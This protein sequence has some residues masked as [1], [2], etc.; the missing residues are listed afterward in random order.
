MTL[1]MIRGLVFGLACVVLVVCANAVEVSLPEAH[2]DVNAAVLRVVAAGGGRV[3]VPK[4][5]WPTPSVK[6]ASNV[7]LFLADGARIVA[8]TNRSDYM[9]LNLPYCEG[10]LM[11]IVT[12]VGATNVAITGRG[13]IFGNGT[14]WPQPGDYGGNQEGMRPR[15][16]VFANCRDVRL[17]DFSL[18]DSPCWGIVIKNCDGVVA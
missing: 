16:I 9:S 18:R 6:L 11:A 1:R 12:A 7:E 3:V 2:G 15:G 14:A 5:N 4:G 13:E 17:S 10:D 8:S